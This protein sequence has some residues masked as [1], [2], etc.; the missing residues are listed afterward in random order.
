MHFKY[1]LFLSCSL[2]LSLALL[3]LPV[4]AGLDLNDQEQLWLEQ[5]RNSIT[6]GF[7]IIPPYLSN[8][9]G[10]TGAK[11]LSFDYLEVIEEALGVNFIYRRYDNYGAM[12]RDARARKIDVVFAASKTPDRLKYLDFTP[13]YSHLANKIFTRKDG[14]E[15]A[16]MTDFADKKF[17]VPAG[18]ALVGYIKTNYPEIDLVEVDDLQQ[19]FT[20]LSA[21][22]VD[23][24]GSYASAGYLYTVLEGIDNVR[25][26]GSVGYD[27]H[28]SF[29]SRN[30]W[31]E[32][33]QLLAKALNGIPE[34]TANSI[35]KRWVQ[36]EDSR[37]ELST[38]VQVGVYLGLIFTLTALLVVILWNRSLKREIQLRQNAQKEI[39]FLAYHDELT[40]AY[41][42]QFFAESLA[43]FTR[44]PSE[45]DHTTCVVLLGLDNFSLIND[46]HGQKI[47]DYVLQRV[48]KRIQLRLPG[49]AVL[50][51]TGGDEFAVLMRCSD[52]RIELGHLADL[53][54]AELSRPIAYGDQSFAVTATAGIAIQAGLLENS[55]R[56]LEQADIALHDAKRKNSGSYIFY[57][58]ELNKKLLEDQ[59]LAKALNKALNTD[60]F[61]LQYQPQ[62]ALTDGRIIGFEA[63][64]RWQHPEQ[65]NIP[66]D[67]FIAIAEQE[68]IIVTL[69]DR[70]LQLACEQGAEWLA[71][72]LAFE[73]IAVNVSVKQFIESDFV[74]KVMNVLSLTGFPGARLELEITESLFMGNKESAL[75]T[76]NKL[77]EQGVRF[78]I[79]DFGT[80]FSSL[81]Y[82]KELPVYK[83]KLDRGFISNITSDHSSL[84]I[85]KASLQMGHALNMD[86]IAEGVE[87][88][89]EQKLLLTLGC[90]QAQGYLFS[91]PVKA[92]EIASSLLTDISAL[93]TSVTED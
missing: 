67:R 26:S 42:R 24:V 51:R 38:V 11:G 15:Q 91:R 25:I 50:A 41:N 44:L 31:P 58:E 60:D 14:L 77:A 52:N 23:G 81:L 48:V 62:V 70:V 92:S 5:H 21:G 90:D 66:P 12:I 84:Q 17:A 89:E 63:L 59:M 68:G 10:K 39:S 20:L 54:I 71:D 43:E 3:V 34:A 28:I 7:A 16:E 75:E 33:G 8:P 74:A 47:G 49:D 64:A 27:Y 80:G 36:P 40:G 37:V 56:L 30:D 83:I 35:D 93:V 61:Y 22:Q 86:V 69:G 73:R 57:A 53:M 72:G 85:V 45:P 78:S 46:V 55:M 13:V 79:D 76:M 88:R 2:L 1:R 6:V 82:L 65:G 29:G 4:R 87:T 18:T 9:D 19:A 32:L